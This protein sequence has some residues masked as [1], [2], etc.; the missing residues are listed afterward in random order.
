[1][2]S[3]ILIFVFALFCCLTACDRT[4]LVSPK[5]PNQTSSSTTVDAAHRPHFTPDRPQEADASARV[6]K[7]SNALTT[8]T[9]VRSWTTT[10]DKQGWHI[11]YGVDREELVNQEYRLVVRTRVNQADLYLFGS[12]PMT[13]LRSLGLDPAVD[14]SV[15]LREGD[16]SNTQTV[17]RA[18]AYTWTPGT[19]YEITLLERKA[20][21]F[22][23]N[24]NDYPYGRQLSTTCVLDNFDFCQNSSASWVAW[25]IN[26]TFIST[27]GTPMLTEVV[28]NV[29]T[30]APQL[31]DTR[32][33]DA[34]WIITNTPERGA[35]A[36]W[37]ANALD[38]D[39]H[40]A[41]VYDISRSGDLVVSEY[42]HYTAPNAYQ[43]RV[44]PV[45]SRNFPNNFIVAP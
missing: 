33:D 6:V 32:L 30:G 23:L 38:P 4:E 5:K 31:W 15:V 40:V 19:T 21:L 26:Q 39:G 34:G 37:E 3:S 22:A 10:V 25:K 20:P 8:W 36:Q 17:Y 29:T 44:I 1:M 9:P 13:Q 24:V 18:Y 11:L 28:N 27:T 2:K 41:F 14:Y 7:S 16:L 45:G 43:V 42:D 12:L 35:I